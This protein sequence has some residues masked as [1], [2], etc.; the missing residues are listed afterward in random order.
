MGRVLILTP[1]PDR[2]K[3][4]K[5]I[6]FGY[7]RTNLS[8]PTAAMI[9]SSELRMSHWFE[10]DRSHPRGARN[11]PRKRGEHYVDKSFS[12]VFHIRLFIHSNY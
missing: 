3:K 10:Q 8:V 5:K 2:P 4:T 12:Y 11:L 9:T 7:A 1:T 6:T